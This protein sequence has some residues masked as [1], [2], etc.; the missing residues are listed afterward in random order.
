MVALTKT[1]REFVFLDSDLIILKPFMM[2]RLYA[3]SR[4]HDF[5]ATYRQGI[6]KDK[7][8]FY[9]SINSGFYFM[10]VLENLNYS[11]MV[12]YFMRNKINSDQEVLSEFVFEYYDNWDVMSLQWHCR[13]LV[14]K[15]LDIP[16]EK[17]Y[18]M[19]TRMERNLMLT[20][21][22]YTLLPVN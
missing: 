19:H 10:R 20:K 16:F 4:V 17:C 11:Q 6:A 8:A 14:Q 7:Q 12:T 2:D 9:T 5:L 15:G 22:N 1:F 18:T 21:L 13:L 3:R